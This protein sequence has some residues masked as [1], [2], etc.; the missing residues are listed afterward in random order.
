M[1]AVRA[2]G[3]LDGQSSA[4]RTTSDVRFFTPA[5][6]AFAIWAPIFLGELAFVIYQVCKSNYNSKCN[7]RQC[8]LVSMVAA[9]AV[10]TVLF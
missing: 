7:Y 9:L 6:W 4:Q 1:V 10:H 2:P 8:A 3:R 5:P